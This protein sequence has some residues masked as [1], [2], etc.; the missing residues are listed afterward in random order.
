MVHPL[1][2]A[3]TLWVVWGRSKTS[4][5]AH[6]FKVVEQFVFE[7]PTLQLV[8]MY[9]CQETKYGDKLIAY[10]LSS[11]TGSLFACRI[12]LCISSEMIN[13]QQYLFISTLALFK[14]KEINRYKFK[15]S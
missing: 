7:L 12:S 8:V 4:H 1:H 13:N 10:L 5:S 11:S 14:M 3:V 15:E 9:T 2:L 6:T